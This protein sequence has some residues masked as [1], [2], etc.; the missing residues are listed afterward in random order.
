ML[1]FTNITLKS[2]NLGEDSL[3]P[4]IHN[5]D[6]DPFFICDETIPEEQKK[7]IGKGMIKTILP[8]KMQ[9]LYDRDFKDRTYFAAVLENEYLKATF[10]PELGGRLWSL[11]NKKA[12]K[13][14][15]YKN[16]ALIFANLAL[17]NAWFA[18]GSEWNIGMKGHSPFTCR[19]MFTKKVIG[20][21]GHEILK[22]YEYE[23]KR[24]LVYSVNAL[25]EKDKLY[26][27]ID[28]ENVSGKPTY[29]YWWSNVASLQ[30]KG[31]RCIVPTDH[32]YITSYRE[33]GYRIRR[34]E[35]PLIDGKDISYSKEAEGTI[36]YFYDI[37]KV[38]KNWISCLE[39]DGTG[40]LYSSQGR[41]TGKKTFL[42]GTKN[43]GK[44]WNKW[45]TDGRDYLEIQAGLCKTQF[46]H[47]EIEADANISWVEC[48]E[49]IDIGSNKG[50]FKELADKIDALVESCDGKEE[51]FK[52]KEEFPL[53]MFGSGK[54]YLASK[55]NGKPLTRKCEFPKESVSEKE[56]YYLDILNGAEPEINVE[57]DFMGNENIIDV[58]EK[59][60]EKT[61]LDFYLLAISYYSHDNRE[62]AYENLSASISKERHYL[63]LCA[64]ALMEININGDKEKGFKLIDEA[65]KQNPEYIP[66]VNTYGEICI[67]TEHYKEFCE[68]YEKACEKV[69]NTGR[70]RMYVAQCYCMAGD[71]EKADRYL[72]IN[73]E[74]PDVREGEYAVSNIWVLIY[75]RKIAIAENR[76][77]DDITDEEVLE[78]YP[79]PYEIDFR[80]H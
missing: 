52:I 77:I 18:G 49:G 34:Q 59:K 23:E 11:Y 37:P 65:I 6:L 42:W 1:E 13:D 74:V 64:M 62:K 79:I 26:V 80:L 33:G 38:N 60:A 55:A 61:W 67:K 4:D 9:N 22:M 25:L 3:I 40:L 56:Q 58:I 50:D 75:K 19:K 45:L 16:D 48:Y 47:F 66:L 76:S 17:C 30:T 78:K 27:Y 29:M 8:Y 70:V 53:V 63:P 12:Q 68:F 54:G 7:N 20:E 28:V 73:L 24:G 69:K 21:K 51:M 41:L 39:E 44:H 10:L 71:I 5:S 35:I 14:I 46:E 31:T 2:G 57:T 72:N 36:D 43:G 15:V 32:S